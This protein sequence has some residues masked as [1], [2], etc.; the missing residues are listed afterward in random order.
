[1]RARIIPAWL[2]QPVAHGAGA[3]HL[4]NGNPL[5]IFGTSRSGTELLTELVRSHPRVRYAGEIFG[6]PRRYPCAYLN[7]EAALARLRG[8]RVWA[9][10]LLFHQLR[11]YESSFGS[12]P[13]FLARLHARGFTLVVLERRNRLLQALSYIHAEQTQY[14]FRDG[15]HP[16]FEQL[17][18]DPAEVVAVLHAFHT[19]GAWGRG[20]LGDLPRIELCY[21]D[22]LATPEAQRAATERVLTAVGL[23]P[24]VPKTSLVTVAPGTVRERVRNYDDLAATL[25]RTRFASFLDESGQRSQ[26]ASSSE[27]KPR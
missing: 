2:R 25:A 24:H 23:D 15:E 13:E 16:G 26:S 7:G 19:D 10:K 12:A 18:V 1:M 11:W 27:S 17:E 3:L 6:G 8:Y 4:P 5:V 22:D 14:H 9:F 21:E 20:V